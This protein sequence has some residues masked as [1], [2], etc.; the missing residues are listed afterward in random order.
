MRQE[1]GGKGLSFSILD[2]G[3]GISDLKRFIN[4]KSQI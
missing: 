4:L 2:F 1:A 3:L